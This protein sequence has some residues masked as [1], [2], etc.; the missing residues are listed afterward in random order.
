MIDLLETIDGS[1]SHPKQNLVVLSVQGY[2]KL[3]QSS[4]FDTDS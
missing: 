1:G 2:V 3:R 4:L